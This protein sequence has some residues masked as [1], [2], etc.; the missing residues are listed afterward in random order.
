MDGLDS[1]MK[2]G[3]GGLKKGM[4]FGASLLKSTIREVTEVAPRLASPAPSSTSRSSRQPLEE[5]QEGPALVHYFLQGS[6][7]VI[8][9]DTDNCFL[10]S[11]K[12]RHAGLTKGVICRLFPIKGNFLFRFKASDSSFGHIWQDLRLDTD[13]VPLYLGEIVVKVFRFPDGITHRAS[14]PISTPVLEQ[15][16]VP[17]TYSGKQMAPGSS[18]LDPRDTPSAAG[19][20][21]GPT[22]TM[23]DILIFDEQPT[24]SP[25]PSPRPSPRQFS[26]SASEP[27][28]PGGHSAALPSREELQRKNAE[29]I[30]A[31]AAAAGAA[32]T[33]RVKEE[34]RMRTEKLKSAESLSAQLDKWAFNA[35][36]S[37]K[38]CRTLLGTIPDVM[39]PECTFTPTSVPEL[40]MS[41]AKLKRAYRSCIL[42][43]HPDRHQGSSGDIVYRAERIF[44]HV[45]D[46]WDIWRKKE[47]QNQ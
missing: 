45:N 38:D 30:Q 31:A 17:T 33:D 42:V 25:T 2:A 26:P 41:S 39:W 35:D 46:A 32:L 34:E 37:V 27:A 43:F 14:Q 4:K 8:T 20:I 5:L 3:M 7:D 29:A 23:P 9:E 22:H 24:P 40:M 16:S 13:T 44:Q 21:G 10:I 47:A 11:Q 15:A 6:K 28:P 1:S 12:E 36:G 19:R 18:L